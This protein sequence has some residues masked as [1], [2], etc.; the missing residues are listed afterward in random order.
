MILKLVELGGCPKF[1]LMVLVQMM[2][3]MMLVLVLVLPLL[4]C[5]GIHRGEI[6]TFTS[7]DN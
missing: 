1:V 2:V 5:T 4:G 3:M 7:I 6:C